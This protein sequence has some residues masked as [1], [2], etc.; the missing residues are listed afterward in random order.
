M[1]ATVSTN[2]ALQ[3]M[4]NIDTTQRRAVYTPEMLES[5]EA[6]ARSIV[7]ASIDLS[8]EKINTEYVT[9]DDRDYGA[10]YGIA[11]FSILGKAAMA[12]GTIGDGVDQ[13]IDPDLYTKGYIDENYS[14]QFKEL[15][16]Q[17]DADDGAANILAQVVD[18]PANAGVV[19]DLFRQWGEYK[20]RK[21][22]VEKSGDFGYIAGAVVGMT[23]DTIGSLL[24]LK[25]AGFQR[26]VANVDRLR[27]LQSAA[28]VAKVGA[29]EG[30]ADA[31][32]EQFSNIGMT[33]EDVFLMMGFG[34]LAGGLLGAAG[35]K[36]IGNVFTKSEIRAHKKLIDE[37]RER[38]VA[39]MR[40]ELEDA[41]AL[42]RSDGGGEG[43]GAATDAANRA[44]VSPDSR[45][46]GTLQETTPGKGQ[47]SLAAN[48]LHWKMRNPRQVVK[49]WF[50]EGGSQRKI[51]GP[52]ISGGLRF[53]Q[54]FQRIYYQSTL[55]AEDYIPNRSGV[56]GEEIL[57]GRQET[58]SQAFE[59]D[60]GQL[61]AHEKAVNDLY[62]SFVKTELKAG[63][64]KQ[65]VRNQTALGATLGKVVNTGIPSKEQI[66]HAADV[67]AQIVADGVKAR[68]GVGPE[69][70]AGSTTGSS[71]KRVIDMLG[72]TVPSD[73]VAE[74]ERVIAAI[75]A[76]DDLL[77]LEL[78]LRE[79]AQGLIPEKPV[80]GYRPQIWN[81]ETILA[82]MAEFKI[83]IHDIISQE[84]DSR[85]VNEMF[86]LPGDEGL[87]LL[88]E[89]MTFETWAKANP[90]YASEIQDEWADHLMDLQAEKL[91]ANLDKQ[92]EALRSYKET[93]ILEVIKKYDAAMGR[94]SRR[95]EEAQTKY[96]EARDSTDP[97]SD[98]VAKKHA[99]R[100]AKIQRKMHLLEIKTRELRALKS[101]EDSYR[102]QITGEDGRRI[103]MEADGADIDIDAALR[104]NM[105]RAE[106]KVF[107]GNQD[108]VRKAVSHMDARMSAQNKA[109]DSAQEITDAITGSKSPFGHVPDDLIDGSGHFKRRSIDLKGR[110]GDPG[111]QKFLRKNSETTL[112]QYMN[113]T[114]RQVQI[115]AKF[116]KLL[117]NRGLSVDKDILKSLRK[118]ALE[119]Y[120]QDIQNASR[121]PGHSPEALSKLK[122]ELELRL[123]EAG[124]YFDRA[125]GE[126]TRS[127]YTIDPNDVG[128][129]VGAQAASIAQAAT[130]SAALGFIGASLLTDLAVVAMAGQRL[131]TGFKG[132]FKGITGKNAGIFEDI[133][134]SP[135]G[136]EMAMYIRGPN[137]YDA[138]MYSSRMDI[139]EEVNLPG[140][141]L[142]SISR[143]TNDVAVKEGWWNLMH[144]WNRFVRG[145][146]GLDMV[147]AVGDDL[148]NFGALSSRMKSFYVKQ[149]VGTLEARRMSEALKKYGV[150]VHG[151][152]LP[153]A[154]KWADNGFDGELRLFKRM[155]QSAGD[156]AMLDPSI[157]DRPFL[158]RKAWG[159]LILQFQSFT[160]KAGDTWLSPMI[161]AQRI[162]PRDVR[163]M[164]ATLLAFGLAGV[165]SAGRAWA[166]GPEEFEKWKTEAFDSGGEGYLNLAKSAFLRSPFVV[167]MSGVTIDTLGT[168]FAQPLNSLTQGATGSD[169]KLF[170]EEWV[171]L[172]QNQG[173]AGAV[174][175]PAVGLGNGLMSI[176]DDIAS[177][178][179]E[180]GASSLAAKLPIINTMPLWAA[181]RLLKE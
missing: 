103:D 11:D 140:G 33:N 172:R 135:A 137:T 149:G 13:T 178:D 19:D 81:R 141:M 116:K 171:R 142:G 176:F 130:A 84:V 138:S 127:D 151:M 9:D 170:N 156:E 56:D 32:L 38:Q 147:S 52:T 17:A 15:L 1:A 83:L 125:F 96:K 69:P 128:S 109:K 152:V 118:F 59:L 175:G 71:M 108:V 93:S 50:V 29:I 62:S 76:K 105:S 54:V 143:F 6:L 74:F 21:E 134:D 115:R 161:Q 167:G 31:Y 57:P 14:K 46:M 122:E 111:V 24:F 30:T 73:K 36:F 158:K 114:Q 120:E 94:F 139:E 40:G 164:V 41:G 37:V 61:V 43:M 58:L 8:P 44:D 124:D 153:D 63:K 100:A 39:T 162:N 7:E 67:Y 72:D 123:S 181:A 160:Y 157:G 144:T 49:D 79:F 133:A 25:G 110:R 34:G 179:L 126:I 165:G 87:P 168:H 174:A 82:N 28:R 155:V 23:I 66:R 16:D 99:L 166:R 5:R 91:Q 95:M 53:G 148:A 60:Q 106:R 27:R 119:G 132:L 26:I 112:N 80:L 45:G 2:D 77:Y 117:E 121:L 98:L 35:P 92:E 136:P 75:A 47:K 173:L 104:R 22:A 48:K 145:T 10:G 101:Q 90:E 146:F 12:L 113:S 85:W 163:P 107:K 159:R 150:V 51:F 154:K 4:M 88:P 64:F 102:Y 65:A 86:V 42:A 68:R 20:A 180:G 55:N 131:G 169:F 70:E 18:G 177:G 3:A 129:V 97:W 78:G 89:G